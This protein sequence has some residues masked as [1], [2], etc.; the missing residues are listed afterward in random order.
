VLRAA[1]AGGLVL[2]CA[3]CVQRPTRPTASPPSDG[4]AGTGGAR[5]DAGGA[6]GGGGAASNAAGSIG[7]DARLDVT[8]ATDAATGD[9]AVVSARGCKRGDGYGHHSLADLQALSPGMVWWY[10]WSPRPE[11]TGYEALGIE[12]VPMVWG[13]QFDVN[14]VVGQIPDGAR[15]LLGF[16]EPNFRNQANLTPQQAA[17]LWPSVQEIAR[18]KNLKIVSPAVNYCGGACNETDPFVWLDQFFAACSGCQ[19]DHVAAHLYSCY[20]S[21]LA[22]YL[23]TLKKYGRPIWLTEFACASDAT[24]SVATQQALMTGAVPLMENDPAIFRYAWF[25]G[26]T[27]AAVGANLLAPASGQL[28]SL[29]RQYVTMPASPNCTP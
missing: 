24:P 4:S 9:G 19:I 20:A 27:T 11:V 15:Y 26:R 21:G 10:N 18:R 6:A 2:A 7:Q 3:S 23:N 16:N 14:Q 28:T 5:A 1:L 29:G 13:G 22:T 25:S 17:A 8:A 12:F